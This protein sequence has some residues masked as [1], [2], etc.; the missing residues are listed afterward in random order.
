MDPQSATLDPKRV[1]CQHVPFGALLRT[2]HTS[3]SRLLWLLLVLLLILTA[4]DLDKINAVFPKQRSVP[5]SP[6]AMIIEKAMR[7]STS[8]S[9]AQPHTY[10][11][12]LTTTTQ[13]PQRP[14]ISGSLGTCPCSALLP[15]ST[16]KES[17][18][19]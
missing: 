1:F 8:V 13:V 15:Q 3:V 18:L 19:L 11:A 16:Y 4:S 7:G 2:T 17:L 10:L 12:L 9:L 14:L 5:R 6:S